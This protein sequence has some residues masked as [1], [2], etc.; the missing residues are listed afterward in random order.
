MTISDLIGLCLT[1]D[2]VAVFT[3]L[4]PN[5]GLKMLHDIFS[6]KETSGLFFTTDLMVLLDIIVRQLS[7][8]AAGDEVSLVQLCVGRFVMV[9]HI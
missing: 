7:D 1:D 2:P 8:L 6:N 4:C 5:S 3:P 9:L